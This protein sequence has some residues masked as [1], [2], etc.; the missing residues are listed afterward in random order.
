VKDRRASIPARI[1]DTIAGGVR[2]RQQEREPRAV[3]YD[4]SGVARIVAAGSDDQRELIDIAERLVEAAVDGAAAET[5][6]PEDD[7]PA[8]EA[9]PE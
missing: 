8:P 2:R 6:G 3:I 1:A 4:S 7:A 9:S 5:G